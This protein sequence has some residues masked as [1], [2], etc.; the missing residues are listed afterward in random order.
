MNY[1]A[2]FNSKNSL[3]LFG[4]Q[5]DLNFIQDLYSKKITQSVDVYW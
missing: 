4:L 3:N 1:P 2:F 5:S